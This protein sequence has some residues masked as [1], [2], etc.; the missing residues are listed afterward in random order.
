MPGG[1][2]LC[3][4]PSAWFLVPPD[5]QLPA[6]QFAQILFLP[7][8]QI[9]VMSKSLFEPAEPFSVGHFAAITRFHS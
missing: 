5:L 7:G 3:L 6:K 4:L 2:P 1:F 8:L 9:V